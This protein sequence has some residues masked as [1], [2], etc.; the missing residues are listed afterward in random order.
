KI[1][2]D[3]INNPLVQAVI[4]AAGEC[5]RFEPFNSR[6]QHKSAFVLLDKPIIAWTVEAL[7]RAG[8]QKI[9]IIKSPNDDSISQSLSIYQNKVKINFHDQK[10]P[11]GM[12]NAIISALPSLDDQFILLN[13][14]QLNIDQHLKLYFNNQQK[15]LN[16]MVMFCQDTE[17]PQKYGILGLNGDQVT[18]IVEKPVD[19]TGLSN[20]RILGIYLLTKKFVEFMNQ[21]PV[22]EYQFELSLDQ[23]LKNNSIKAIKTPELSLSLKYA[24][25]LFPIASH[26]IEKLTDGKQIIH[27][28]T[29]IHPTAI[30]T[31]PVII[32]EGAE[33]YEYSLI[34]GPVYIGKRTVVGSYSKI[35]KESVM[36][37]GSQIENSV[38][39]K[40]SLIGKNSHVHSGFVGDSIIGQECRIGAD[41]VT[42]NRRHDRAN[43]KFLIKEKVVDCNSSFMGAL[44]G[45]NVKIGIHSGTNPGVIIQSDSQIL[46]GSIVPS[47]PPVD[48]TQ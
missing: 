24:W 4:L 47:H 39:L 38:E 33:I 18:K 15:Y 46:P 26:L 8:I 7:I 34:Q 32:E 22:S 2:M 28:Q 42:A 44:I 37:E 14:Q 6:N 23:Y 12:G 5:S 31:G 10:E 29:K 17:E 30:I 43:I 36:E 25:D 3:K 16:S 20:Q 13:S 27:P 19:L 35:R 11:L 45:D 48:T 9:E 21:T 41:F 40:H 1:N